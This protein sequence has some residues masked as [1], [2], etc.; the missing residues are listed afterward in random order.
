MKFLYYL[1]KTI[2]TAAMILFC[3]GI[4]AFFL[5]VFMPTEV[6]NA[7]KIFENIFAK[8][9]TTANLGCII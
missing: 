9:L 4:L 3:A 8:H 5:A 6:L 7:I 1:F 2:L